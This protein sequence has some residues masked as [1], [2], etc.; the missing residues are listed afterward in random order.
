MTKH[1]APHDTRARITTMLAVAGVLAALGL[2]LALRL[3][4]RADRWWFNADEGFY[5][6]VATTPSAVEASTVIRSNAH[7]PLH[8][9]I[10]RLAEPVAGDPAN[11][12][13][14]LLLASLL[15]IVAAGWLGWLAAKPHAS[16]WPRV[17]GAWFGAFMVALAPA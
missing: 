3:G 9:W 17:A 11:L 16:G 14:I 2:G 1:Q 7:P 5:I 10:L 8:Y 13:T 6:Q 15:G 12:R 4:L